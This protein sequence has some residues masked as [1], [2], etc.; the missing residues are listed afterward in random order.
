MNREMIMETKM[1]L[2]YYFTA[3]FL[4]VFWLAKPTISSAEKSDS[5]RDMK[6]LQTDWINIG[7]DIR[8]SYEQFKKE[9]Q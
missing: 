4:S 8:K 2:F 5:K 7:K 3:G 6:N 1:R 9:R